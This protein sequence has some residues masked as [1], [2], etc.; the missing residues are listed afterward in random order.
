MN[1]GG[2]AGAVR[3]SPSFTHC[4]TAYRFQIELKVAVRILWQL[5]VLSMLSLVRRLYLITI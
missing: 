4:Y 5:E 1:L 3:R 2:S